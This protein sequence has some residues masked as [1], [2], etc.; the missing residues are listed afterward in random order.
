LNNL[1]HPIH[2]LLLLQVQAALKCVSSKTNQTNIQEEAKQEKE[3]FLNLQKNRSKPRGV[4]KAME[5][6]RSKLPLKVQIENGKWKVV[7]R[8]DILAQRFSNLVKNCARKEE[9]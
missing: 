6:K 1:S 3:L 7:V 2:Q 9:K 8:D 4:R 5:A